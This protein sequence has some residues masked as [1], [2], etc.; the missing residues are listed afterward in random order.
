[1]RTKLTV[2]ND[3]L[4]VFEEED[5]RAKELYGI[6]GE[7]GERYRVVK[8]KVDAAPLGKAAL[9]QVLQSEF[10]QAEKTAYIT[11]GDA[12]NQRDTAQREQSVY[13]KA[14]HEANRAEALVGEYDDIIGE[15]GKLNEAEVDRKRRRAVKGKRTERVAAR[16]LER[17]QEDRG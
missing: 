9:P 4:A 10:A 14:Q 6:A 5:A 7:A 17:R 13:L 11:S 1:M 3:A 15:L 8:E 16:K 12:S 2:A